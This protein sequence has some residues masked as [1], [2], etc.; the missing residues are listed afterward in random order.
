MFLEFL[1]QRFLP[2]CCGDHRFGHLAQLVLLFCET[3]TKISHGSGGR[4]P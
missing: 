2:G 1:G 3:A 4:R